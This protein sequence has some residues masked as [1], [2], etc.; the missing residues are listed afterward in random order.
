MIDLKGKGAQL[1]DARDPADFAGAHLADSLDIG[2][3]GGYA[4]WCG[5]LLDRERPIVIV[6]DPGK[7]E[8]ATIRL[9]RIGF[10]YVG[11]YLE[12]GMQ[13]LDGHPYLLRRTLR[14]TATT[15]AERLASPQAPLVLDVRTEKEWQERRI[16][17]SLNIPLNQLQERMHEVPEGQ[18]VVIHCASG[19]RSSIASSLWD[20][21][22]AEEGADLVGGIAAW[23]AGNLEIV[24]SAVSG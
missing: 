22:R 17:G 3:G 2:L 19:Y 16:D 10:D 8:E 21:T 13:A 1:L 5:T 18:M 11:G 7:E 23:E 4:T 6:V 24:Q 14:I 12:G 20:Q 15:L 9:G